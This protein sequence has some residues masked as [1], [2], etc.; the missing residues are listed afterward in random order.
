M[1]Y[2]WT[3]LVILTLC[4]VGVVGFAYSGLFEARRP[5]A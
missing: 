4:I 2:V 3:G 5:S 1:K